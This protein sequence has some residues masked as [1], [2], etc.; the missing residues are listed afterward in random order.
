ML[1][2]A[3]II[4]AKRKTLALYIDPSGQLIVKAPL[5]YPDHKI[6][7]FVKSKADWISHRQRQTTQNSYINKNVATY[8]TFFFLGTEL[9]PVVSTGAKQITKADNT[10]LIPQKFIELGQ[11]KTLKKIKKLTSVRR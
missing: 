1:H 9:T 7:E 8:Q 11:D 2:P 5:K 4:R 6:F 3:N 10:L